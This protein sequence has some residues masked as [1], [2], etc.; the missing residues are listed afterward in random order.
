MI[1]RPP[2]HEGWVKKRVSSSMRALARYLKLQSGC[3]NYYKSPTHTKCQGWI[4]CQASCAPTSASKPPRVL[5]L[6]V[7]APCRV[8]EGKHLSCLQTN[9]TN[10]KYGKCGAHTEASS[11][12]VCLLAC[13]AVSPAPP[14][15]AVMYVCHLCIC[16][17]I[18]IYVYIYIYIHIYIY[19][20]IY[21]H[22]YM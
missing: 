19:I 15:R 21:T 3:L 5:R 9:T 18:C 13:C 2:H 12:S 20:Y 10:I 7:R 4:E 1:G 16:L 8:G 11:R 22:T 6:R 14:W 17:Y